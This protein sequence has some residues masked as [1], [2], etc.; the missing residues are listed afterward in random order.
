MSKYG[1]QLKTGSLHHKMLYGYI[2]TSD[3]L[4]LE[5]MKQ[6]MFPDY[7]AIKRQLNAQNRR[8]NLSPQERE[9][10]RPLTRELLKKRVQ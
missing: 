7:D 8:S 1:E 10:E 6:D 3:V 5:S 2:H 4:N 9:K